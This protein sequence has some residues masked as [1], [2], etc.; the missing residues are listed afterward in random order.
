[1][2][3]TNRSRSARR[4]LLDLADLFAAPISEI[5]DRLVITNET[6][7]NRHYPSYIDDP[8]GFEAFVTHVHLEDILAT[9]A[10]GKLKRRDLLAIGRLLIQAWSDRLRPYLH[11][12]S[13]RFY[14]GGQRGVILRFHVI[15]EG[16]YDWIDLA[17]QEFLKREKIVTF[18]L[19]GKG[20][21]EDQ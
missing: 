14:L 4:A 9:D 5:G 15:R 19:S 20:L 13:V 21:S 8:I 16:S 17:D 7:P 11:D 3:Y 2:G 6:N 10:G 12:R 1:M 18:T